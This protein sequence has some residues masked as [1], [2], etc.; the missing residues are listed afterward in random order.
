MSA[1]LDTA[2]ETGLQ[3]FGKMSASIS[4]EIKNVLAVINENAGLLDDFTL[5]AQRGVPLDPARL[6][7]LAATVQK[8]VSR[9]DG[10]IKKMNRLAHSIDQTVTSVDPAEI[11]NLFISLTDRLTAMRSV[12]VVPKLHESTIRI[13]TSPFL[14]LNLLWLCLEFAMEAGSGAQ[15]IELSTEQTATGLTIGFKQLS[16]LSD[17]QALDF[18]SEREKSLLDLLEAGLTVDPAG[19]EI[20]LKL[21]ENIN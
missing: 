8:H 12:A 1:K 10:I 15:R 16:G 5:M 20:L 21:P 4:H 3:F 17:K 14:L 6:N 19:E 9:G 13:K 18:P 11:V 7:K 2:A